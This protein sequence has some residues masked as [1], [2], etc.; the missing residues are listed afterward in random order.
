MII[1][2]FNI[3]SSTK[4]RILSPEMYHEYSQALD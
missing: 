3:L 1:L 4:P 2:K